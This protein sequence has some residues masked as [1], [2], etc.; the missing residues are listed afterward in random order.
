MRRFRAI[1]WLALAM[2]TPR[3]GLAQ[4]PCSAAAREVARFAAHAWHWR[5]RLPTAEP[6]ATWRRGR[7]WRVTDNPACCGTGACSGSSERADALVGVVGDRMFALTRERT[8]ELDRAESS[9]A[10]PRRPMR[11]VAWS[12]FLAASG[13]APA[14]EAEAMLIAQRVAAGF[15]PD[16][17]ALDPAMTPPQSEAAGATARAGGWDVVSWMGARGVRSAEVNYRES[18]AG[19]SSA[20]FRV[21]VRIRIE[22]DGTVRIVE[23]V[24]R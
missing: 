24:S 17:R 2:L 4:T 5:T 8:P 3:A 7:I 9:S 19:V 1:V 15:W 13:A 16:L 10:M 20:M 21:L 6:V 11:A 23:A 12:E 22:P 18:S 14:I